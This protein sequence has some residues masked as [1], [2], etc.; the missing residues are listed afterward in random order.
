LAFILFGVRGIEHLVASVAYIF[1][2]I[3]GTTTV[4]LSSYD[5]VQGTWYSLDWKLVGE[6]SSQ[7][8]KVLFF[9]FEV[10]TIIYQ[11]DL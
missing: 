8:E 2:P 4:N 10:L 3:L 6:A 5:I 11:K 7:K 9:S 1:A